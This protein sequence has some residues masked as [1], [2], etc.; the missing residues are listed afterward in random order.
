MLGQGHEQTHNNSG[1]GS[2]RD[3][4]FTTKGSPFGVKK[5]L[6]IQAKLRVFTSLDGQFG[7]YKK[8]R[9]WKSRDID[10]KPAQVKVKTEVRAG[11]G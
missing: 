2:L 9:A 5:K 1:P 7:E 4:V 3:G 11:T 6:L 10:V 8:Q